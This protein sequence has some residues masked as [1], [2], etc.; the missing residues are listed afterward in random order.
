MI[1]D[2]YAREPIGYR[3]TIPIFSDSNDY[4]DNYE[5]IS[6]DHLT[7]LQR[8]GTNP[9]IPEDLWIQYENS[10]I[11]LIR[12]YAKQGDTIL[13]VGVGLGRLLSDF[14]ELQRYGM[15]ISFGYLDL[16]QS[17]WIEVCY[18][19]VEDMPYQERIF[20]MVVCTDILEHML[21]LNLSV[22]KILSVLKD[23]GILIARVPYREDLSWYVSPEC[24]YKYVHLRNFDENSLRLLFEQVFGC[25]VIEMVNAGYD[26]AYVNR[27]KFATL[28]PERFRWRLSKLFLKVRKLS[29]PLYEALLKKIY[30]SFEINIVLRKSNIRKEAS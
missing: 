3:G 30:Y 20:D 8:H 7:S 9:F 5:Q 21:D 6:A 15:D 13:D 12:K 17:K 10:T 25:E 14:P 29:K 19:L 27:L 22:G 1:I 11:E 28:I 26:A 24:K 18:A 23:R 2:V 16:A 4:T